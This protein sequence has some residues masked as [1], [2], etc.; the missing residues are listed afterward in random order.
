[1]CSDT[2]P[3]ESEE[4]IQIQIPLLKMEQNLWIWVETREIPLTD[5]SI[6]YDYNAQ[7]TINKCYGISVVLSVFVAM[8]FCRIVAIIFHRYYQIKNE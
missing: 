5:G 7:K 6:I 1:M 2:M 4:Y 3:K 8:L